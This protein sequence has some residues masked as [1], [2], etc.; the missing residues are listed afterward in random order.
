MGNNGININVTGG[1]TGIGNIVQGSN[2]TIS[3]TSTS[4]GGDVVGRDKI[5]SDFKKLSNNQE[6]VQ[7]IDV[8]RTELRHIKKEIEKATDIDEDEKDAIVMELLDK[9]TALKDAKNEASN[10]DVKTKS[11]VL[12]EY[13]EATQSTLE[14]ANSLGE[15]IGKFANQIAPFIMKA[16]QL[17][18]SAKAF[19]GL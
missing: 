19:I 10:D 5:V 17:L 14:K 16:S 6:F 15:K 12:G 3:E 13:L 11:Q 2:N 18:F 7:C 4:G 8:L 1:T 9:I